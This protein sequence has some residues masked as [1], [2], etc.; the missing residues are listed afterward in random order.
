MC[1]RAGEIA[2]D[3]GSLSEVAPGD[4]GSKEVKVRQAEIARSL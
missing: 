1:R 4:V 2:R 3:G